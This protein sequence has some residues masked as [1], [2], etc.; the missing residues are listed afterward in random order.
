MAA[1][2]IALLVHSEFE[3]DPRVSR[4][5]YAALRDGYRV[6]V[7]SVGDHD[8][9]STRWGET[10]KGVTI[11]E[12]HVVHVGVLGR[13]RAVARRWL[14]TRS[15]S[16]KPPEAV[17]VRPDVA[18]AGPQHATTPFQAANDTFAIFML[19]RNNIGV[20]QQFRG[21]GARLVHANDL[22]VLLAG[23]LLARLWRAPLVYDSHE[24]W[25]QLDA[26]WSP[27]MRKLLALLEGPLLRRANAVV[28][29]SAPIAQELAQVYG[30][31]LPLVVMNCPELVDKPEPAT[32]VTP[33]AGARAPARRR[34]ASHTAAKPLSVIYQGMLNYLACGLEDLIDAAAGV[35][36]LTLVLRGPGS[37]RGVLQQRIDDLHARNIHILPPVPMAEVVP[38]LA[39]Y[40]VGVVS[41]LP[42]SKHFL[43]AAPN[44][45]FEY[46]MAGLAVVSSDLPVLRDVVSTANC[47]LLYPAGNVQS[48][49][50]ALHRLVEDRALLAA[51]KENAR[52]AA[53][54]RYNAGIEEGRLL[55]LY[56]RLLRAPTQ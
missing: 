48:L 7:L 55:D 29:V 23:Y 37:L 34:K 41:Y 11:F 21:I 42:V 24:L 33:V 51:Y 1:P 47:G 56:G 46:M 44:K 20:F 53:V 39:G 5:A 49:A 32:M 9:G 35:E 52:R 12:T 27:L 30:A 8:P 43:F 13:V 28:T 2:R 14:A 15:R 16:G 17:T 4:H 3:H 26:D 19:I 36:D 6:A 50:D 10:V 38:A 22:N 31:P 18:A 54:E 40:D 25:T 45:L